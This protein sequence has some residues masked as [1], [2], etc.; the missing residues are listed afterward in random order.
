[1]QAVTYVTGQFGFATNET[2]GRYIMM[3]LHCHANASLHSNHVMDDLHPYMCPFVDCASVGIM[4][5]RRRYLA[6][7]LNRG[8]RHDILKP[9][10]FCEED[11][12]IVSVK[13]MGH[14]MEEI[15]FGTLTTAYEQWSYEDTN[16]SEASYSFLSTLKQPKLKMVEPSWRC[17]GFLP[18]DSSFFTKTELEQHMRYVS[19]LSMSFFLIGT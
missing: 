5:S 19:H 14:H 8:H 18:C 7:H 13:H 11:A 6:G 3:P 17:I 2:G 4:W 1:M 9:C 12:A 10:P 15:A 16:S